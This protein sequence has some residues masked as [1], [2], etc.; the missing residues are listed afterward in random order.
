[1]RTA[2]DH[3]NGDTSLKYCIHCADEDGKLKSFDDKL[4]DMTNF[5]IKANGLD[6]VTARMAAKEVLIRMPAWQNHLKK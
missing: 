5:I 3:P 4:E 2:E 6:P 1:M